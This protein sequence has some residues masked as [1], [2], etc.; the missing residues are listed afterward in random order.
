MKGAPQQQQQ[1]QVDLFEVDT[2][3]PVQQETKK[4]TAAPVNNNA[5]FEWDA[6]Q[7]APQ[8]SDNICIIS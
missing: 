3:A 4:A 8:K 7:A 2:P 1:Q 5:G 6:P